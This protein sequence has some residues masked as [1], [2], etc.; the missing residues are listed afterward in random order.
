[1]RLAFLGA[2]QTPILA[3]EAMAAV[4]GKRLSPEII[5]ASAQALAEDLDP[6]GDIYATAA[7][8]MHLARVLT[9]R[10]L[11]ALAA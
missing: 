10:A 1:M 11:T 4:E 7:T 9:G 3:R 5:A 2:G 6:G 8:K